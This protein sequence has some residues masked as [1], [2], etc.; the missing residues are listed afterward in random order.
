MWGDRREPDRR[1]AATQVICGCV[2][3]ASLAVAATNWISRWRSPVLDLTPIYLGEVGTVVAFGVCWLVQGRDLQKWLH[4]EEH[5]EATEEL[6]QL[7]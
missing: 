1:L 2:I 7:M 5:S 4:K 6:E 3:F